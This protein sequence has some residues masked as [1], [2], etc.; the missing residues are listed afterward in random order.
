MLRWLKLYI[1]A[2][3]RGILG[4]PLDAR[5]AGPL[6]SQFA[7]KVNALSKLGEGFRTMPWQSRMRRRGTCLEVPQPTLRRLERRW[8][9]PSAP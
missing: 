5:D 4:E 9:M 2:E 1:R 6:G 3:A 8:R 7:Q